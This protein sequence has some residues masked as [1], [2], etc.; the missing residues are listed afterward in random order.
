MKTI[1]ICPSQSPG[2]AQLTKSTPQVC[3]PFMGQTLLNYWLEHLAH[4]QVREVRL[5]VSDRPEE[6]DDLLALGSRWGLNFEILREVND[7]NP[8]QARAKYKTATDPDW[9]AAP[10]DVILIDHLPG[11]EEPKPFA[12]YGDW[13]KCLALW[14]PKVAQSQ[15]IGLREIQPGVWVGRKTVVASSAK[16]VGPCWIGECVK[17]GKSAVIGPNA[18]IED[19]VVIDDAAEVA[20]SWVG[21]ATF[22]GPLTRV[23]DSLAW[24]SSLINWKTNSHTHV[25][26][27][28]LMCALKQERPAGKSKPTRKK[29]VEAVQ[30]SIARPWE[31]VIAVAQKIQS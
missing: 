5:I 15:R 7:I 21:P 14:L 3:L 22:L 30:T 9:A 20:N 25:P 10:H 13:F 29:L 1:L 24:G 17:I 12:S 2:L 18:F 28:F 8:A 27:A 16:L 4:T 6:M 19:E 11:L 26:D 31:S 23:H